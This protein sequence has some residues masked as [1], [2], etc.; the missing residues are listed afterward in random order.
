MD[1]SLFA[2][3]KGLRTNI[4]FGKQTLQAPKHKNAH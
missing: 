3:S 4:V 1:F 2:N